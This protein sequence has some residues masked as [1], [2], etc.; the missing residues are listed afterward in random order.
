MATYPS[1]PIDVKAHK[2]QSELPYPGYSV[3]MTTVY[4]PR[5]KCDLCGR[6]WGDPL[7]Y[8]PSLKLPAPLL[9]KLAALAQSVS[10]AELDR[11][12][13]LLPKLDERLWDLP[14]RCQ[15]GVQRF[16]MDAPPPDFLLDTNCSLISERAL[17]VLKNEGMQVYTGEVEILCP[18]KPLLGW[19]A[20]DFPG[21][22]LL[23][24]NAIEKLGVTAC[25]RCGEFRTAKSP[26]PHLLLRGHFDHEL[27]IE[28]WPRRLGV[29]RIRETGWRVPSPD[30]IQVWQDHKL[31]GIRFVPIG[32]WV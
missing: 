17:G 7:A 8:H 20:V 2:I 16:C 10:V 21:L 14:P 24:E 1:V 11:V 19:R 23:S 32:R 27:L 31:T 30:F 28:H 26:P 22:R 25:P 3:R 13:R 4:L 12:R 18:R 6:L 5:V 9:E 15:L 29:A